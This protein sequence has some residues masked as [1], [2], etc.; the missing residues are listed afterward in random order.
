[1]FAVI[2]SYNRTGIVYAVTRDLRSAYEA[3]EK[4]D[5]E[6]SR[7]VVPCSD[8][9]FEHFA[10]HGGAP[11]PDLIVTGHGVYLCSEES[12]NEE[13]E[14]LRRTDTPPAPGIDDPEDFLP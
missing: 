8:A 12:E 5:L 2:D 1:M 6:G 7:A 3:A 13:F 4:L 9:A 14:R 10:R 11:H